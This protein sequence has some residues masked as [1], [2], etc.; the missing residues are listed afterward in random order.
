MKEQSISGLTLR[1][2]VTGLVSAAVTGVTLRCKRNQIVD[3]VGAAVPYFNE[4][5]FLAITAKR[6]NADCSLFSTLSHCRMV[7]TQP[8]RKV[9]ITSLYWWRCSR[10]F[11]SCSSL[12]AIP[13][14]E[15]FI[16]SGVCCYKVMS[17]FS[18]CQI[19]VIVTYINWKNKCTQR[20]QGYRLYNFCKILHVLKTT[21]TNKYQ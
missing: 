4:D 6:P 14:T 13:A 20:I 15:G 1:S 9:S 17:S 16:T 3:I 5:C 12:E 19:L 2:F 10:H 21:T 11:F 7:S 8:S 18:I